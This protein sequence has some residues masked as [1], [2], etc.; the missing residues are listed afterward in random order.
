VGFGTSQKTAKCSMGSRA[1]P[2]ACVLINWSRDAAK[3]LTRFAV[4]R[5]AVRIR[6]LCA[7]TIVQ[8]R[9]HVSIAENRSAGA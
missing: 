6:W 2:Y 8:N 9:E 1:L 7:I 3:G 5:R 4:W